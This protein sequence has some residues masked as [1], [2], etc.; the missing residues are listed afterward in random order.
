MTKYDAIKKV[1][2]SNIVDTGTEGTRVASGTTGQRGSTTGQFRFNSTTGLAEY[3]DGTSFKN[4]DSAPVVSSVNVT[5]VDSNAGGNQSIVITGSNFQSGAIVSFLGNSGVDITASSTTINSSTQITAVAPKSSFLNA[6]EPY[7]IKVANTNGLSNTL[8]D[9]INVDSAPTWTTSSGQLG[10]TI[11]ETGSVSITVAATDQDGDTITYSVQSGSLPSG[12][13]LNSSSGVISGT[14]GSVGGDTT[15]SFTLRATANSKTTDRSFSI[16]VLNN[17]APTW[18]TGSG[19]LGNIWDIM[20]SGWSTTLSASDAQGHTITYSIVSG[21]LPSGM[22]LNSSSGSI[23]GTANAVGSNS[24]SS[25]TARASDGINYTDRSFSLTVKAP[26]QTNSRSNGSHTMPSEI[27]K[28][29]VL[30]VGGG[31]GGGNNR[32]NGPGGDG[33]GGGVYYSTSMSVSGGSNYNWT[34]GG[35]GAARSCNNQ[36]GCSGGA[37]SFN[38]VSAGMGGGGMSEYNGNCNSGRST[39]YTRNGGSGGCS[40]GANGSNGDSAGTYTINGYTVTNAGYQNSNSRWGGGGSNGPEPSGSTSGASGG[41][42]IG[43]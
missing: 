34:I 27:N 32:G 22:S 24:T 6:Q 33:G 37:S 38:G 19:S 16:V 9:Q 43:Y 8:A 42:V 2:F 5:E 21:S 20:R 28:I 11:Y 29:K 25:F 12:L 30:L 31:G 13:S 36:S 10:G 4:I 1:G 7:T 14:A 35:G 23:S 18:N 17:T 39:G 3:Y 40:F 41:I 26:Y 15:S